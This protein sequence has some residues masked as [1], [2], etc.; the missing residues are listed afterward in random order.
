MVVSG[1]V[2][3]ASPL[4]R[5]GCS[6]RQLS[7]GAGIETRNSN[8]PFQPF[9]DKVASPN[10]HSWDSNTVR[11]IQVLRLERSQRPLYLRP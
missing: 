11:P 10:A 5:L 1:G 8:G 3:A 4:S 2:E 7:A 9:S 6:Q